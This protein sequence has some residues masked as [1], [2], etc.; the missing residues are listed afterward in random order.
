MQTKILLIDDD[1]I[2]TLINKK[3]IQRE[4]PEETTLDFCS[5]SL[6]LNF[7]KKNIDTRNSRYII[8]LDINMPEMNGW[9]FMGIL[10]KDF[11]DLDTRIHLLTS[12]IDQHDIR[13]AGEYKAVYSYIVKPLNRCKLLQELDLRLLR[14]SG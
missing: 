5:A 13:R 2:S 11:S 7:F 3:I 12:S 1:Y 10:E 9:E 6:A 14:H 4:F 8:F